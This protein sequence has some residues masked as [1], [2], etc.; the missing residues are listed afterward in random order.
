MT[1]EIVTPRGINYSGEIKLLVTP[2]AT[3]SL[4]ILPEHISLLTIVEEG[5][6]MIRLP[7]DKEIYFA[8]REGLLEVKSNHLTL[9]VDEA[10]QSSDIDIE[11][12][13]ISLNKIL[14]DLAVCSNNQSRE[15]LRK[16]A[17]YI[18]AKLNIA[19]KFQK[20]NNIA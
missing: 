13:K 2:G 1:L 5:E 20:F 11:E 10:A 6:T 12:E 15:N 3:G 9:L 18:S 14:S 19:E 7:D 8:I 17:K 4:G 16:D